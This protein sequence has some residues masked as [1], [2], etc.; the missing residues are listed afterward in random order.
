MASIGGSRSG[1][2]TA[3]ICPSS[4]R[5]INFTHI[6]TTTT[7]VMYGDLV[8]VTQVVVSRLTH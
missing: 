4:F 1:D 5:G 8:H 6:A 7:E 3:Y 2:E